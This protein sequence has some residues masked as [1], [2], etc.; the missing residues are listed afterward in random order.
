MKGCEWLALVQMA[1]M[2]VKCP[3]EMIVFFEN[4]GE[5]T[6]FGTA[7]GRIEN[8]MPK[9]TA[10][11]SS[12]AVL[13]DEAEHDLLG[14]LADWFE[15]LLIEHSYFLMKKDPEFFRKHWNRVGTIKHSFHHAKHSDTETKSDAADGSR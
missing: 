1:D 2:L 13:F 9:G 11:D 10:A 15:E 12:I 3:K 5:A 14:R 4:S 6:V 8:A 7:V